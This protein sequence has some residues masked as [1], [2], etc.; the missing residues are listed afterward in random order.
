MQLFGGEQGE[1]EYTSVE[2]RLQ[3][4]CVIFVKMHWFLFVA[5]TN[6]YS[7]FRTVI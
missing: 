2:S 4:A 3:M 7:H 6:P 5:M 1:N